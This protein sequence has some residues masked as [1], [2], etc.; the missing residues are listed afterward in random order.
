MLFSVI[1]PSHNAAKTIPA[2]LNGLSGQ[3][4]RDYEVIVVDDYSL[5][6]TAAIVKSYDFNCIQLKTNSG[7]AVCRNVGAKNAKGEILV[8]TDSDC[9]VTPNWLY[10]IENKFLSN[11]IDAIMGRL[12][13]KPSTFLGDSISALGFPAGGAVGFDKIWKVDNNGFTESLSTCNCAIRKDVFFKVSGFDETFPYPGGEDSYL[14]YNLVK[15]GYRIKYCPDILV[16]H[17]ARKSLSGFVKWQFKR[18]ISSFIFSKKVSEKKP[19]LSL[20]IW[21]I[22]NIIR[23][24]LTDKK[25]PLVLLLIGTSFIVQMT[26]FIFARYLK[27]ESSKFKVERGKEKK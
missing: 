2:L 11:E 21:S 25:L 12:I 23:C 15:F 22:K 8:F 26:G 17:E 9:S 7:P 1:I 18:G 24:Y 27:A 10:S 6:N 14:A 3:I 4:Y 16:Y 19:F 20:R 5:D 13:L